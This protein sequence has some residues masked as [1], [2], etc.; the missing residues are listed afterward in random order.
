MSP[1]AA[2]RLET[3]GFSQ[4]FDY[5]AGKVDWGA[6]GLRYEGT[7]AERLIATDA[8]D[9]E[10]P[11]CTLN[12][13]FTKVRERVRS[14]RFETCIVIN[15]E[16]VV[17]G[18]LGRN[19]IRSDDLMTVEHAMSEG[20]STVRPSLPLQ[21]LIERM[22]GS[23]QSTALV[24]TLDGRLVGLVQREEAERALAPERSGR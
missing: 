1:R 6:A 24:T 7:L 11:T 3:L 5:V 21:E 23:K 2:C 18:R 10:V 9:P 15:D 13:D 20:P 17:L 22:V 16:R 4:V 14:S 19:A 8:A 12:D